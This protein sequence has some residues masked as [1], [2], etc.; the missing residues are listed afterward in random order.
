MLS[1]SLEVHLRILKYL[2]FNELI[3]VKQTNSY[4]CNLITKYEGELARRKFY[5]L[6]L[7]NS[8]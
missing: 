4:F 7:V 6:S 8:H 1:L 3:S 5:Y 2:N